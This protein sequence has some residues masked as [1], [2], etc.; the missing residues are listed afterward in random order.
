[1]RSPLCT[2]FCPPTA[3][4]SVAAITSH[5]VWIPDRWGACLPL[6]GWVAARSC[7]HCTFAA[8]SRRV[9][10]IGGLVSEGRLA[11]LLERWIGKMTL[12]FSVDGPSIPW[13]WIGLLH[14]CS[15]APGHVRDALLLNFLWR[16]FTSAGF[17]C[18]LSF[19]LVV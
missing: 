7:C 18:M 16:T 1:V 11:G 15:F 3:H 14:W 5:C 12:A 19:L 2:S 13:F 10:L 8:L 4:R 17:V 9:L 6:F